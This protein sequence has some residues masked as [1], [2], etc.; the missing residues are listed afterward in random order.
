MIFRG[1]LV[2]GIF[3]ALVSNEGLKSNRQ[4]CKKATVVKDRLRLDPASFIFQ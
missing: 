2:L 4:S 3:F 1:F